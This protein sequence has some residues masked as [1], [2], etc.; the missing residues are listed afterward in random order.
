MVDAEIEGIG[1]NNFPRQ[2][3]MIHKM[4]GAANIYFAVFRR[5]K[6]A[7]IVYRSLQLEPQFGVP[8]YGLLQFPQFG[9]ILFYFAPVIS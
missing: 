6:M 4:M 9:L 7:G 5:K 8:F 3:K 1:V 2:I